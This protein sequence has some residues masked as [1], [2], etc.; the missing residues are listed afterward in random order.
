MVF[1]FWKENEAGKMKKKILSYVVLSIFVFVIEAHSYETDRFSVSFPSRPQVNKVNMRLGDVNIQVTNYQ[2]NDG[3]GLY[4]I[5]F[6][7]LPTTLRADRGR[8]NFIENLFASMTSSQNKT[9]IYQM[10]IHAVVTY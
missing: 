5:S 9:K 1:N 6:G 3:V 7:K 4:S 2:A 10:D 8:K